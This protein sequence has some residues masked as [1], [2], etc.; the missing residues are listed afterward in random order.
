MILPV[1]A[2]LCF[3]TA[4]A[5]VLPAAAAPVIREE[6]AVYLEDFLAKPV[7]LQTLGPTMIFYES[8]LS[9]YLGTIPNGQLVELQAVRGSLYRVRGR[10]Q[11]GGVAGWVKSSSLAP[12]SPEFLENLVASAKRA[13]AVAKFIERNEV[14][15]NMTA[16]EVFQSLGKPQKK[17]SRTDEAGRDEAWEYITY[18]RVPQQVIGYDRY[19]NQVVSYIYVKEPVGQRAVIF[20]KG[21]VS[22]IEESEGTLTRGARV[23]VVAPPIEFY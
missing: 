9:R 21:L 2:F 7:R 8:D 18:E 3:L 1:K 5:L 13:A 17:S 14:A 16:P 22:S 6:G 20:T 15:V 12:L 19:G 11:Q 4:A 10:A 23:S